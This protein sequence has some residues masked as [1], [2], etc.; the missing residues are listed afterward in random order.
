METEPMENVHWI[1]FDYPKWV[2]FWKRGER[3]LRPYYYMWQFGAYL[4]ARR[5]HATMK[6]D[7]AHHITF[8]NYWLPSF[9]SLLPIPF[10]WGPVGGAESA[11]RKFWRAFSTRGKLYEIV[12]GAARKVA[13]IDP[14]VRLTA[15]RASVGFSTTSVTQ[16]RMK[17]LGCGDVTICS[18]AGLSQEEIERL[19]SFPLRDSGP[20][21]V[22]SVGRLLHWKGFDLGLTAFAKFHLKFPAS[23]YWI[24]G[25][26]P[27]RERLEAQ[28][29]RLGIAEAVT[30]LGIRPR[31]ELLAKLAECDILLHPSLHDSGGWVCLEMMAAG[32]PIV[33]LNLGG[34]A[35]QVTNETGFRI[36]AND[37]SQATSELADA[38]LQL[39]STPSLRLSMSTQARSHIRENFSWNKKGEWMNGVYANIARNPV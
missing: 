22:I 17:S 31:A 34:P 24:A 11:P 36:D 10:I 3:G 33:C 32:R 29:H 8:V 27:E 9:M 12:R 18:E 26:G 14:F 15:R 20:F 2:R 4:K 13:S 38:L 6:F 16:A 25:D 39:A 35:V 5:L 28:A 19:G 1:F 37:P 30:F 23:E 21:R 7:L